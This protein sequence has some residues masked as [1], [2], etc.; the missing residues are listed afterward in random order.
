MEIIRNRR[1]YN[2]ALAIHTKLKE[3]HREWEMTNIQYQ[4]QDMETKR[5]FYSAMDELKRFIDNI[6]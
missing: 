5:H 1:L 6:S 2:S 4:S 3:K